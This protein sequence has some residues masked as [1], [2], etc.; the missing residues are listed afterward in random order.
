MNRG[1]AQADDVTHAQISRANAWSCE[2][3]GSARGQDVCV[4]RRAESNLTPSQ[5][6]NGEAKVFIGGEQSKS[7]EHVNHAAHANIPEQILCGL[8]ATL[9]C[10]VNFGRCD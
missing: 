4:S 7:P 6:A 1:Q 2:C 3:T 9:S 5:V 10:F 8:G